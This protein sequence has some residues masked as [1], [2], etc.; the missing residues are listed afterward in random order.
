MG[1]RTPGKREPIFPF[2]Q[3]S[4]HCVWNLRRR[5]LWLPVAPLLRDLHQ[6]QVPERTLQYTV[7]QLL[8]G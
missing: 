7:C 6:P 2:R 4:L 3:N 1:E 8:P 5:L